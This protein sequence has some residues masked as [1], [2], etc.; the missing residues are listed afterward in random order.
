L[1]LSLAIAP[2]TWLAG[3]VI[4]AAHERFRVDPP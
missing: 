3:A 2:V 1:R 4:A